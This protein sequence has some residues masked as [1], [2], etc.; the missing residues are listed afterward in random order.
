MPKFPVIKAKKLVTI[1][2]R[3]GF[4]QH[5]DMNGSHLVLKHNDGRRTTIPVHGKEIPIGTLMAILKDIKVSRD[6]FFNLVNL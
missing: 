1:L 5:G 4:V 2:I 3:I 6:D